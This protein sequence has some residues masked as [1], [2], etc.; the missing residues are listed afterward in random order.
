MAWLTPRPTRM[1][2]GNPTSGG[3]NTGEMLHVRGGCLKATVLSGGLAPT[4]VGAA[5]GVGG[6][7]G[8]GNSIL[9]YSGAGRLN[10]ILM[11][12]Q[13]TSGPGGFFYDGSALAASGATL[14]GA[15]PVGVIP[16]TWSVVSIA[17]GGVSNPYVYSAEPIRPDMPFYSGLCL[18]LPSGNPGV[19]VS[20]TPDTVPANPYQ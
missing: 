13:N 18:F 12:G 16:P 14:V 8:S 17:S 11:L 3:V 5:T 19:T 4:I 9:L 1:L 7:A 2:G 20:F 10:S 15:A 6:V